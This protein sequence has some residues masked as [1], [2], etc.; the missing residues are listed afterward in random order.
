MVLVADTTMEKVMSKSFDLIVLPGGLPGADHLRENPLVQQKL[1]EM[2]E[3]GKYTAA[4]CAAPMA[5]AS[6]GLLENR[7][8]TSYP[9]ALE[10]F[11]VAGM[12]YL[13][14]PVVID[15]KVVTSRG[16]GTA[17]DFALTLIELIAGKEKRDEVEGAL[18]RPH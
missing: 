2:S 18:M 5:L 10:K 12:H 17:M 8:V 4:I 14:Q 3:Q 7:S 1:K 16:P 15:G 6:A 9:G 11:K 13:E